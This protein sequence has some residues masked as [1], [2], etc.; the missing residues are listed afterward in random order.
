[1]YMFVSVKRYLIERVYSSTRFKLLLRCGLTFFVWVE[2]LYYITDEPKPLLSSLVYR[3]NLPSLVSRSTTYILFLF[4]LLFFFFGEFMIL[5]VFNYSN[6]VDTITSSS[7]FLIKH[8]LLY[9][10]VSSPSKL[11]LSINLYIVLLTLLAL[12]YLMLLGNRYSYHY[13]FNS[14]HFLVAANLPLLLYV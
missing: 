9:F 11:A 6:L 4:W 14:H 5:L 2:K 12:V 10:L 7:F 8:H 13:F 1:M 3:F